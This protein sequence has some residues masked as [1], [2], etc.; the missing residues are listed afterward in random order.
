MQH[1]SVKDFGQ[2]AVQVLGDAAADFLRFSKLLSNFVKR[3][4]TD[5]HI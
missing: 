3:F 1:N 5:A 2:V 4:N